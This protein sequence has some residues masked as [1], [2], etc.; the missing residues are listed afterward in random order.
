M[1]LEPGGSQ[2]GLLNPNNLPLIIIIIIRDF[3]Y[4]R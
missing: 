4:R 3:G 2:W 1:G